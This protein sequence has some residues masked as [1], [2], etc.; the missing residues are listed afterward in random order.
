MTFDV[1]TL[2]LFS[3]VANPKGGGGCDIKCSHMIEWIEGGRASNFDPSVVEFM[4]W[5]VEHFDYSAW[6]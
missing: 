1:A 4:C 3:I 2:C 6:A 5:L